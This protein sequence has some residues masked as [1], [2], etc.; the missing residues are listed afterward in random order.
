MPEPEDPLK[1]VLVHHGKKDDDNGNAEEDRKT[2]V[3]MVPEICP[4][5]RKKHSA[6]EPPDRADEEKFPGGEMAQSDDIAEDV[7][8][9]S[10]DEEQDKNEECS[11]MVKEIIIFVNCFFRDESVHERSA[12]CLG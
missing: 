4:A 2:V 7:L 12:E 1:L 5:E 9:K 10:G 11:F 3:L 6:P 8:W